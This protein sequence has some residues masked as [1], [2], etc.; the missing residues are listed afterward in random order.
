RLNRGPRQHRAF[1]RGHKVE[2]GPLKKLSLLLDRNQFIKIATSFCRRGLLESRQVR[3][4]LLEPRQVRLRLLGA[5]Q[6]TEVRTRDDRPS[7]AFR[8]RRGVQRE[9]TTQR[10]PPH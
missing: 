9:S 1:K 8:P 2:I 6:R 3:L 4:R 5:E 7:N 10:K